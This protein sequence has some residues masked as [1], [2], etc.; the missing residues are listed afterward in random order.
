MLLL[1]FLL[2]ADAPRPLP[3][4]IQDVTVYGSTALVHRAARVESG[5]SYLIQ[6][7]PAALDA[8]NVRVKSSSG[9]VGR[10]EVRARR[11][12]KVPSERLQGLRDRLVGLQREFVALQD[13]EAAAKA[14][15]DGLERLA[16]LDALNHARDVQEGRGDANAWRTGL[17]FLT[18]R[19]A[20]LA[21]NARELG[22]KLADQRAAI[23]ALQKE[24]GAVQSTPDVQVYDVAVELVASAPGT[25]DVEYFV[26]N[27]GWTPAYDVRASKDLAQVELTYRARVWQDTGEEWNDVELALSTAQPQ[28]G[29]QGP[30]PVVAWVDALRPP[31]TGSVASEAAP[32]QDAAPAPTGGGPGGRPVSA[33]KPGAYKNDRL[34]SGGDDQVARPFAAVEN[35][36]LSARFQL[37][38]KETIPS[39]R[40]ATTVL[41]GEHA[42]AIQ[43]ERWCVPA[44]DATVWL[45][46]KTKNTSDWILLPGA[47]SVFLGADYVGKS[48]IEA[49]QTGQEFTL[50]LGADPALA[51]TR[52]QV[53]DLS[54]GPAF[55]S[56]RSTKLDTW[57]IRLENHGAASKAPD[58]AVEVFV[59][60][61][62]PK[63][64]DERVEIALTTANPNWS[65]APRWKQDREEKG[66][67]T[68]VVRVPKNEKTDV[69]VQTTIT[70][71]KDAELVRE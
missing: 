21:K 4:R 49:V 65:D 64:K 39:R 13:D 70:Y 17:E 18:T 23:D 62:L 41:V 3:T 12:S 47:A 53:Q 1:A 55:L 40:D 22:W 29:A 69:V 54:K 19:R 7:L 5:G 24:I 36:G 6:G 48:A 59:R 30:E 38:K 57:R 50:H 10:V 28:K 58:G 35:L 2:G 33:R 20:E 60:E 42:L 63:T 67:H 27:T 15:A 71:P 56:N 25:L 52:T 61:V 34:E 8:T 46:A 37:A 26:S 45:R 9:D 14:L 66:I 16:R 11:E 68:W 43:A 31:S 44:L 51:V 32:M